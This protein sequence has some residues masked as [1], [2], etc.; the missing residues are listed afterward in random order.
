MSNSKYNELSG[1]DILTT[2]PYGLLMDLLLEK[3][4]TVY[5][6]INCNSYS[7]DGKW[8]GQLNRK[9]YKELKEMSEYCDNIIL[10]NSFKEPI[11]IIGGNKDE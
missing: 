1:K 11:Q 7:V 9:L 8:W 5:I 6:D 4:S 10:V 2:T 3:S